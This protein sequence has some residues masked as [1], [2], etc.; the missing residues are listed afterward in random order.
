MRINLWLILVALLAACANPYEKFYS[1]SEN[2][3]TMSGY[4]APIGALQIY[5]TDS[6]ERDVPLLQRRGLVPIGNSSFTGPSSQ[7]IDRNV[8]AQAEK[9]GAQLVLVSSKYA[10]TATGVMPLSIPQNS[11]SYTSGNATVYGP[12]G[13]LTASGSS[14]TNTFGSQTVMMPYSIP[15]SDFGAVYFV[16]LHFRLGL[17]CLPLDDATRTRLQSNQG[18]RVSIVVEGSPA[19]LADILPGDILLSIGEDRV[20]S[21]EHLT[22]TLYPKYDGKT[23]T[24]RLDREGK[25]IEK[26]ILFNHI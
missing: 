10:G 16:R 17:F 20:Q 4:A 14:V 11:T 23:A 12:R 19:Y 6:F 15:R 5:S 2:A 25:I 18:A 13:T 24:V 22:T 1:G 8:K 26:P 3:R 21:V 9:I 7:N